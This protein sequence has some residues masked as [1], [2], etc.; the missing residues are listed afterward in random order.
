[1]PSATSS[2]VA[3]RSP[4]WSYGTWTLALVAASARKLWRSFLLWSC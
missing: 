1:M 4:I 2:T 3:N